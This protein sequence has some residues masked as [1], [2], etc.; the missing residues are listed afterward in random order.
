MKYRSA[1]TEV[2]RE[3]VLHAPAGTQQFVKAWTKEYTSGG[4]PAKV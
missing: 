4:G 2:I 1:L 3:V